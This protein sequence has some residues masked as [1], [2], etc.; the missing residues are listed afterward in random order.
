M[1]RSIVFFLAL[2]LFISCKKDSKPAEPASQKPA[3]VQEVIT[4]LTGTDSL[5]DFT[6]V[7]SS[8]DFSTA[9]LDSITVFAASNTAMANY[10]PNARV[11]EQAGP[12]AVKKQVIKG[13]FRLTDFKN[14]QMLT[15]VSGQQLSVA[16]R[17]N[18]VW[19]NGILL[20]APVSV[21]A[22]KKN[23][24]Y[25]VSRIF[26]KLAPTSLR[27][28]VYNGTQWSASL[29]YGA[30]AAGATVSLYN[31]P[32]DYPASPAYTKTTDASG[33]ALFDNIVPGDY[34]VVAEQDYLHEKISS[35]LYYA[36]GLG[37]FTSDSL[38][39][40]TPGA[41]E[42]V[43]LYPAAGNFRIADLNGDGK[44]DSN[45]ALAFPA[46]KLTVTAG[47]AAQQKVL[48]GYIDNRLFAR[49]NNAAEINAALAGAYSKLSAFHELQVTMDAVY[50]DDY[51]C[52]SLSAGWCTLNAYQ[53]TPTDINVQKYWDNG[54]ALISLAGNI[55]ANTEL[56]ADMSDADKKLVTAQA[57]AIKGYAYLQLKNY[58]GNLPLQD[59]IILRT[60][61]VR[62]SSTDMDAFMV[63]LLASAY[64]DLPDIP[65]ANDH[66]KMSAPVCSALL[67][68]LCLQKMDYRLAYNYAANI[69]NSPNFALTAPAN[70]FTQVNNAEVI[71]CSSPLLSSNDVKYVFTKGTFMPEFRLAEIMLIYAEGAIEI[72][73]TTIAQVYINQVR[74]RAGL[75]PIAATDAPTLRNAVRGE[76][77]R[78]MLR[79]G[80]RFAQLT[81]WGTA[82]T[83]LT[84]LGF[85]INSGVLPLPI[86]V[87]IWYPNITQNPGY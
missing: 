23:V 73:Q 55:I 56:A 9:N 37:G 5:K 64:N 10:D 7:F 1:R 52:T 51:A 57:K 25:A 17:G 22:A 40:S 38:Y 77:Q 46:K 45:D 42:P 6:N 50:T 20:S 85:R 70:T 79:E 75:G 32:A 62:A 21:D 65:A 84:S 8:I 74:S 47:K 24:I 3:V 67:A 68:R 39:Q 54:F 31:S 86:K 19:V 34:Y 15:T 33:D 71:F 29:P 28:S 63:A 66:S 43:Q 83:V 13:F 27:I 87:M 30:T 41:S 48:M 36:P 16:V 35:M 81:R 18:N 61:A 82:S 72:G 44:I 53:Q 2:A 80:A 49:L 14:G 76:W 59:Y 58:F 12:D 26:G 60:T 4:K 69:I 11:E 78:E